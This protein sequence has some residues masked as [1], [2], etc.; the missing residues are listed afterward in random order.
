MLKRHRTTIAA[1]AALVTTGLIVSGCAATEGS[2]STD[3]QLDIQYFGSV[4]TLDPALSGQG[5]SANIIALAYD[6]LIYMTPDGEYIPDLATEWGYTDDQ[7]TVFE[8]TLRDGVTFSS[9]AELD[10][11]SAVASMTYFLESGGGNASQIGKI[12]SVDAVD[13]ATV[14]ITYEE[15][16]PDAP[17]TLSQYI[18][19]GSIIGPEG[20]EN[21]KELSTAMDG[22]G[23]YIYNAADSVA[24]ATYVFDRN[25]DY[26]NPDA[27][28]YERVTVQAITDESAALS[29]IQTGQVDYTLGAPSTLEAAESAGLNVLQ[30]PFFNWAIHIA[31]REGELTPALA[32]PRVREAIA[33]SIDR[34]AI[35]DAVA[36]DTAQPSSQLLNEGAVGFVPG[37]EFDYDPEHAQQLLAEAGYP[38][39]FK[40]SILSTNALDENAI[41][42]QAIVS[43]LEAVGIEVD[44]TADATGVSGFVEESQTGKYSATIFPMNGTTMG[45]LYPTLR[46]GPRN[47]SAIH[48]ADMESL[49]SSSRTLDAEESVPVYERMSELAFQNAWNIPIFTANDVHYIGPDLAGVKVT[50]LN[51]I[52]TTVAP[53]PQFAWHPSA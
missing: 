12:E 2:A 48:D 6:P 36:P 42:A 46:S 7:N 20:L 47:P 3:G 8:F 29:A 51:P 22:T 11:D 25:P 32:D 40:M 17:W 28:M 13:D 31:D 5:P 18:K 35:V 49:F 41:R 16:F 39:G 10:A 53:D 19:F 23:Q 30:V 15:P 37:L 9:G 27:Q 24:N 21:P 4:V 43:Y 38:D 44:L 52:P 34:Q 50:N 14:R 1:V 33:I 45:L 26:W